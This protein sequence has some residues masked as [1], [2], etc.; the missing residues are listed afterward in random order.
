[1]PASIC[2]V[3]GC[4]AGGGLLGMSRFMV[5]HANFAEVKPDLTAVR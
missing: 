3:I 2:V 1:V 5:T 4:D